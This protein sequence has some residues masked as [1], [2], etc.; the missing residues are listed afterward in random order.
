MFVF[1][2]IAKCELC[3]LPSP[4]SETLESI[5]RIC[6]KP[7]P[8]PSHI[9]GSQG[10]LMHAIYFLLGVCLRGK[11]KDTMIQVGQPET[12]KV[13]QEPFVVHPDPTT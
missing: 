11:M 13:D 9:R 7:P 5:A 12:S 6:L 10:L 4:G 2:L 8:S 3:F 1:Q